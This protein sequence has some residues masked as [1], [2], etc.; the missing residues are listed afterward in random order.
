MDGKVNC[1]LCD[2]HQSMQRLISITELCLVIMPS[3]QDHWH[4]ILIFI[5]YFLNYLYL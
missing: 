2:F 3:A 4:A 5:F 1:I